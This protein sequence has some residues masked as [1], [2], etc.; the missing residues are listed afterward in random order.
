M[1]QHT[2]ISQGAKLI[3]GGEEITIV[4]QMLMRSE[5]G[6]ISRYTSHIGRPLR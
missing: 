3:Y 5:K 4:I 2:K 1:F 6:R